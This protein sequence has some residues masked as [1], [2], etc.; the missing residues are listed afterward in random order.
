MAATGATCTDT[1]DKQPSCLT[2]EAET[3]MLS[4]TPAF[5]QEQTF[6]T[7]QFSRAK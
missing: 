7:E 4:G 2:R 6:I 5:R 3:H 1:F